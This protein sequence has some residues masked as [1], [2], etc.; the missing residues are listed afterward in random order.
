MAFWDGWIFCLSRS[1]DMVNAILL[2]YM[3]TTPLPEGV[4]FFI[5]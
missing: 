1:A 3:G 2:L 5:L 4:A